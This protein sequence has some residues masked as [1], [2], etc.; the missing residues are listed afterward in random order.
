M[1]PALLEETVSSNSSLNSLLTGKIQGI[2]SNLG[3]ITPRC[4]QW[5]AEEKARGESV[6]SLG[7]GALVSTNWRGCEDIPRL[8]SDGLL[9]EFGSVA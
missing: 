9:I 6:L 8:T 5:T 3:P 1:P 2:S 7:P 4:G